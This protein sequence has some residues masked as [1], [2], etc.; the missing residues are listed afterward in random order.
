MTD[1][2][3]KC[4]LGFP[5]VIR[6]KKAFSAKGYDKTAVYHC[7]HPFYITKIDFSRECSVLILIPEKV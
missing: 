7:Q 1:Y 4:L 2:A 6:I 3:S 5:T